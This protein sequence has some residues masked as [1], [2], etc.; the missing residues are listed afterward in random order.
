[1]GGSLVIVLGWLKPK[2][3]LALFLKSHTRQP[4]AVHCT[5]RRAEPFLFATN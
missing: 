2:A 1:M 4:T 5:I 3:V